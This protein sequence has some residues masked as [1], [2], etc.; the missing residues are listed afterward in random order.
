MLNPHHWELYIH[1][2]KYI[3]HKLSSSNSSTATDNAPQT[4]PYRSFH[5]KDPLGLRQGDNFWREKYTKTLVFMILDAHHNLSPTSFT[6]IKMCGIREDSKPEKPSLQLQLNCR[7]NW[8]MHL[9]N[10]LMQRSL[11]HTKF[12]WDYWKSLEYSSYTIFLGPS[13]NVHNIYI[14]M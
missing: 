4:N 10:C 2:D 11:K 12:H 14:Y 13:S 9:N 8:F 7:K 6:G 5:W 3:A 1:Q